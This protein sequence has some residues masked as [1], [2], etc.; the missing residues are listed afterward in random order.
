MHD[1]RARPERQTPAS[2]PSPAALMVMGAGTSPPI[3]F[4]C[5]QSFDE[6]Y[7]PKYSRL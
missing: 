7:V 3:Q 1:I 4:R 5:D 2:A 6:E